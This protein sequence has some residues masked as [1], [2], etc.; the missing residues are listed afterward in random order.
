MEKTETMKWIVIA[1][2]SFG[3]FVYLM[4][5]GVI[6]NA[7]ESHEEVKVRGLLLNKT[8]DFISKY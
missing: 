4:I 2:L 3:L 8:M 7:L 5:G 1:V 6:F